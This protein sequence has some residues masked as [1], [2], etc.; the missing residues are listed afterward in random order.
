MITLDPDPGTH[1]KNACL[2]AVSIANVK[3]EDVRFVFNE[4]EVI[5]HP[6][7][8]ATALA[9]KWRLD[10]KAASEA[11]RK[12]PEYIAAEEKRA[13]EL[14]QKMAAPMM[15]S[16][17]TQAEMREAKDPR[18]YTEKQLLQYIKSLTDRSH[19]YDTCVYA[20]S[21]AA[22]AA[23]NYVAHMLGVTGFQASCA[24]LDFVRRNRSIK[25]P[26]ILLKAEDALYPQ[27]DPIEKLIE[28]L[29]EWRPWLKTEAK[30]RLADAWPAARVVRE[31]WQRLAGKE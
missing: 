25:G 19:D 24:D 5:A 23:F 13:E 3:N 11:Y 30:K 14:R 22:L 27:S 17:T 18:P 21:L 8:D 4:T 2:R 31:H 6:G 1:I 29:D 26:F 20:L 9:E 7:D 15:E 12:S 16:A 28:A 10:F